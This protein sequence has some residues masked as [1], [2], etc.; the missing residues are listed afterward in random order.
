MAGTRGEGTFVFRWPKSVPINEEVHIAPDIS[1]APIEMNE[2]TEISDWRFETWSVPLIPACLL[3]LAEAA[4]V[5]RAVSTET[6]LGASCQGISPTDDC[7]GLA[8]NQDPHAFAEDVPNRRLARVAI[9][10]VLEMLGPFETLGPD[11]IARRGK[12]TPTAC[13]AALG[14]MKQK[15]DV[16]SPTRG[17]YRLPSP[18]NA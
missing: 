15:G 13:R 3:H 6:V 7:Q 11:E 8:R 10:E 17:K 1:V 5:V 18:I 2:I 4:G 14:V 12:I 9:I 16:V